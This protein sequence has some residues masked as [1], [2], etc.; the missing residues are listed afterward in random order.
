MLPGV[1]PMALTLGQG[2]GNPAGR[3][4][5]CAKPSFPFRQGFWPHFKP[6]GMQAFNEGVP[7]MREGTLRRMVVPPGLAF[8][9]KGVGEIPPN[10][11]LTLDVELLSVKD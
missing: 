4:C 10:S 6:G 1:S 5:R 11:T 2:Q 8:G 3:F 7:S 9:D